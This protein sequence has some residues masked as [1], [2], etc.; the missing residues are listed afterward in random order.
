MTQ[1]EKRMCFCLSSV[2]WCVTR[3]ACNLLIRSNRMLKGKSFSSL[4]CCSVNTSTEFYFSACIFPLN[5]EAVL[6]RYAVTSQQVV[7]DFLWWNWCLLVECVGVRYN[8]RAAECLCL[9]IM[10]FD[11]FK[12]LLSA[13]DVC[14]VPYQVV[15]SEVKACDWSPVPTCDGREGQI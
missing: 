1:K 4:V 11:L 6:N 12:M 10:G 14:T 13:C 5:H 2:I 7:F 3:L 15:R 8:E 9:W